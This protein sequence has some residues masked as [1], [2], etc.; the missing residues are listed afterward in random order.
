MKTTRTFLLLFTI[1]LGLVNEASTQTLYGK[2]PS[3]KISDALNQKQVSHLLDLWQLGDFK[4]TNKFTVIMDAVQY[5]SLNKTEL[6]KGLRVKFIAEATSNETNL[7]I[8]AK[9]FEAFFEDADYP[10]VLVAINQFITEFKKMKLG[11]NNGAMS[12]ITKS[13]IKIGFNYTKNQ[14]VAY[15]SILFSDA[16]IMAEFSTIEKFLIEL[17]SLLD[18][19]YKELYLP[20]NAEKL[21]KV[22]KSTQEAK[23]VIIDDI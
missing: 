18:I 7:S 22:K 2:A 19:A 11:A 9:Q 8:S 12:Y 15:I 21:K 20:E 1:V 3:S 13:G 23:D 10:E 5:R 6:Y 16:E 17:K 4:S 14:E